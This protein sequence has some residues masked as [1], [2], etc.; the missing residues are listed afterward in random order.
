MSGQDFRHF[1]LQ[2]SPRSGSEDGPDRRVELI[3][4]RMRRRSWTDAEKAA[5]VAESLEPGGGLSRI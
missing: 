1:G 4:G 5:I 2:S 3:T